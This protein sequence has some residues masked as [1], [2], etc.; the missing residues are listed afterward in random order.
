VPK[1]TKEEAFRAAEENRSL[2]LMRLFDEADAGMRGAMTFAR[3]LE[4]C[5]E[6]VPLNC[7]GCGERRIGRTRCDQRWCPVCQRALAT[8]TAMR[9]E[10]I[11]E[12][13]QWPLVLTLTHKHSAISTL[14]PKE[15]RRAFTKL[16][17][18]RWW[19]ARVK[20]GVAAFELTDSGNGW[21]THIHAL[22][23]CQWLAVSTGAPAVG[24]SAEKIRARAKRSAK[25]VAEQWSLCV[26]RVGGVHVRRA[27]GG[28]ANLVEVVREVLKYAVK[29]SDLAS[30]PTPLSPVIQAMAGSRLVV[31]WGS[32]YRHAACKRSKP[33]PAMCKCGCND[34]VLE[35]QIDAVIARAN[36]RRGR[37]M[38]TFPKPDSPTDPRGS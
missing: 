20:G 36:P 24:E 6:E 35:K 37:A 15:L 18:L 31:S 14:G 22:I 5:G 1:Q 27:R 11:S 2:M 25:E 13:C 30:L 21:H 10:Q 38:V 3:K 17:R 12:A 26:G 8:R 19:K 16:R 34:W 9:Y 32:F 33:A 4:K 7:I 28:R 29:G 23:D